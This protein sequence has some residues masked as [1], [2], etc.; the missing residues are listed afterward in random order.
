MTTKIPQQRRDVLI[1]A[2]KVLA[3]KKR[4]QKI[5]FTRTTCPSQ[6]SFTKNSLRPKAKWLTFCR[7]ACLKTKDQLQV[8]KAINF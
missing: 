1:I 2:R 7:T 6:L 3:N 8:L 4:E 5:S